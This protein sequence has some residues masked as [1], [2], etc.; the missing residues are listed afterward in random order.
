MK[1]LGV[2]ISTLKCSEALELLREKQVIFTPNPEILLE[3]HH[4]KSYKKALKKA[5]LMLPDGNGLLLVSTLMQIE[6]KALRLTLYP[7]A[8]FIF[9]FWKKPFKKQIPEIIHGS[10]FMGHVIKH[11][12]EN[13]MSVY[14]LGAKKGV[15][16]QTA[17]VFKKKH[18][19]LTIAG[20]SSDGPNENTYKDI[21]K[22]GAQV[23]LV[24]YGAPKQELWISENLKNLPKLEIIMGV[25]GS[26]D[27]WSGQI[28][29]APKW[30]QKVGL[31]WLW[32]L[33]REP[34]KRLKR[35][36]N[37]VVVFPISCLSSPS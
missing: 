28:R 31:E 35:I 20:Y 15:A 29:R 7:V 9:L 26:F 12:A 36:W 27:F 16:Q 24:A 11:A 5:T 30:M 33:I 8:L 23:C 10:D 19:K 22:S 34:R 25:G 21:R 14:F 2:K 6:S 37:A 18:P 3:A 1:L 32:R 13:N 17:E 4:N